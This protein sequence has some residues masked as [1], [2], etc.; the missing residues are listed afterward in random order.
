MGNYFSK[1]NPKPGFVFIETG[2]PIT[3]SSFLLGCVVADPANP[4]DYFRPKKNADA[5]TEYMLEISET[6]Y[7]AFVKNNKD[8]SLNAK[9]GDLL[10]IG[11][12]TS[13]GQSQR[14]RSGF[15]RT[16]TLMQH[17][18]I[19]DI[20]MRS[21]A[22]DDIVELMHKYGG[23]GFL[24]VGFRSAVKGK[25]SKMSSTTGEVLVHMDLPVSA[26]VAGGTHGAVQLPPEQVD[27]T[28][29]YSNKKGEMVKIS[30]TIKG[31]HIFAVRYRVLY[32]K[33]GT[34]TVLKE[35][36][37]KAKIG[38]DA[39]SAGFPIQIG[40]EVKVSKGESF[41]LAVDEV[42]L[43]EEVIEKEIDGLQGGKELKLVY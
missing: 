12:E 32:L 42:V 25:R 10:G 40:P 33:G 38:I 41:G 9:V 26:A 1:G 5:F 20:L 14:L 35:S 31:E 7:D 39:T 8:Q 22:K 23:R 34:A 24:V 30:S 27:P 29:K 15:I 2:L 6:S 28:V 3:V 43:S 4:T 11:T 19:K 36:G 16:R 37:F 21:P 18:D 13:T 17:E